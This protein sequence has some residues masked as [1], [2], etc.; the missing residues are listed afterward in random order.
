MTFK[1][2]VFLYKLLNRN[3][4]LAEKRH[5][6]FDK[7]KAMKIFTF[8][9]IGFWACYLMFFGFLFPNVLKDESEE[10]YDII[11]GGFLVF[12][13]IDFLTRFGLQETPAQIIKPYKLLPIPENYLHSVFLIRIGLGGYNLFWFFFFVPFGLLSIALAPFYNFLNLVGYLLGVWL[14]F[15]VSGYWYL[16]WRTLINHHTLYIL[17]PL[18]VYAALLFFGMIDGQWCYDALQWLLR[19]C[20]TWNPINFGIIV[21]AVLIMFYI[22]RIFQKKF[23]YMEIAK[24]EKIKKVKSREMA[25]LN[26]FGDVG[27]YLKLEIKSILRNKVVKK[28]FTSG[29][30]CTLMLCS[31]FAFTDAY[32][33]QEFMRSFICVYCFACLG[34]ITLTSVMG[35]EG[36][37]IDGL[38]SRKESVLSLLKA[39]YYFICIMM[40]IPVC[41][42]VMPI[43][44]NKMTV[45]EALGCMLFSA[46]CIF[47]FVF[48]LAV[49][50]STTINLNEK[51]TKGTSN[52]KAQILVSLA[53]LFVPMAIMYVLT[54]AFNTFYA[55]MIMSILGTIGVVL[56]PMWLK[57]IYSRFMKR[58][59]ENMAGFRATR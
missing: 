4:T 34:V 18:G 51:M 31:L 45:M 56:H 2:K 25:Y 12:F 58:R 43:L 42:C 19:G 26:K 33:G 17:C 28:Q 8:I 47:P 48:Q 35:P 24:V 39:K 13:I 15:V 22:N 53:A 59:Y 14:M 3:R 36:N 20:I 16:F 55:G 10:A 49:Y 30:I 9:F 50:N 29:L 5:P 44:Q 54:I 27:E 38:M 7:N 21:V 11:N 46:G 37:Y 57:N 41:F 52:S 40:I 32:D 23:V 6:M 1:E